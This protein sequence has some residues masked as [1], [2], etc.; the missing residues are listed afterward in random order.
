MRLIG[1]RAWILMVI[2]ILFFVGMIFFLVT[3]FIDA[4]KWA[5]SYMNSH[6]FENG[7]LVNAGEITDINDRTLAFSEGGIREYGD[8]Q[9]IR[10]ALMHMVGDEKG[11]V[12]TALQV[13]YRNQLVGWDF[14]SGNYSFG[15]SI[16]NTIKTTV[17]ADVASAAYSALDGRSGT[18]GIMNYKTGDI[19]CMVS[20]PS[21]DPSDPP[22]IDENPEEYEGIYLNRL[23]S[24][25]YTPGSIFKLVT[26][27]AALNELPG[28]S[29]RTFNCQGSLTVGDS[30]VTCMGVHGD[31]NIE[32]AL[33]HSCNVAFAEMALALGK[34][35]MTEYAEK[36]G[37]NS[38]LSMDRIDVETGTFDL[39]NA[40]DIDIAWSG[41]GQYT[42]LVNP[43][44]YLQFVASIANDGKP[45]SPNIIDSIKSPSGIPTRI[46]IDLPKTKNMDVSTAKTLQEFMRSCVVENYGE[47]GLSG[48]NMCAKTGTAEVG[49][50]EEPHSWFCGFLDNSSTPYAFIVIVENGGEGHSAA[51]N[52]ATTTLQELL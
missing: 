24:A 7:N 1:K 14:F 18:V 49:E 34:N 37:L 4:P 13:V 3:Y 22:D 44:S 50:G 28:I 2:C 29:T 39:K 25:S 10:R 12:S 36:A 43:L 30:K 40:E 17:D 38:E 6:I 9:N 19:I 35:K 31:Q 8:T 41:V 27:E 33:V 51:M 46:N 26:A 20:S 47:G 32:E 52:V 45:V 48:Y 15:D 11:N 42:T 5:S 23:L 21:F 16:G